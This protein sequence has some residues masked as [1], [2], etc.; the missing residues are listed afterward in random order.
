MHKPS[1]IILDV[2]TA[3]EFNSGHIENARLMDV[4]KDDFIQ[5]LSSLDKNKTYLIYC[6]SGK[7]S[8][9][10]LNLLT[11]QGFKKAYHLKGGYLAWKEETI[12]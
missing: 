11:E 1:A 8:E 12:Q 2:R 4:Q 3:E 5:Q 9:K 6:R 10:A 7:R